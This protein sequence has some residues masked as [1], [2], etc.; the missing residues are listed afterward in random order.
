M[1]VIMQSMTDGIRLKNQL[2]MNGIGATLRQVSGKKAS[3]GCTYALSVPEKAIPK[4]EEIAR[5]MGV[6]ILSIQRSDGG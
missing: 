3:G 2:Q 6:K 1:Y 4:T 5:R